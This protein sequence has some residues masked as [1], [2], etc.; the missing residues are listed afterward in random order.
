MP[1]HTARRS[2]CTDI[3]HLLA[4][5][6]QHANFRILADNRGEGTYHHTGPNELIGSQHH[7]GLAPHPLG[8]QT[9]GSRRKRYAVRILVPLAVCKD[10]DDCSAKL[11]RNQ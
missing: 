2:V 9:H 3:Q 10:I 6:Q 7:V 5:T 11:S 1:T 8:N 4:I